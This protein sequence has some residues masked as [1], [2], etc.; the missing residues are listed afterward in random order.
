VDT[1]QEGKRKEHL[2]H[3]P[4]NSL[5]EQESVVCLIEGGKHQVLLPFMS[6]GEMLS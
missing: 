6:E 2:H 4:W 1:S 3:A 5:K